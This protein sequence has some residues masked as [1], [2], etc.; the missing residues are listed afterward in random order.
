MSE[1][2]RRV[3][4]QIL[5]AA[6]ATAAGFLAFV[7]TEFS[8]VAEL[9]LIAGAGMI[10]AFICTLGFLP[11]AITLF[12]PRG[13]TAEVGFAWAAR[14]DPAVARWRRL[15]LAVFALLA[16]AAAACSPFLQFELGP[17]GHQ[18]R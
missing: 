16:V 13:E 7:P 14:L 4:V 8:G 9:G 18:E 10:M 2:A 11:A 17:A 6:L 5:I 3:G 12:R 1:T 15:I